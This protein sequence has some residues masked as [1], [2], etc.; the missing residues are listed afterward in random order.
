MFTY[1]LYKAARLGYLPRK[2]AAESTNTASK[3]YQHI[4]DAFVV[5]NSS[6][7][8]GYNGTVGV[9]SLNSTASYEVGRHDICVLYSG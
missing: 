2:L 1:T 9:C 7:T 6:G 8:L 5:Q 3:C 4:V